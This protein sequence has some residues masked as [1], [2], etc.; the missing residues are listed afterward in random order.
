MIIDFGRHSV[1]GAI[2]VA[3]CLGLGPLSA[4][5]RVAP[6]LVSAFPPNG[7][8]SVPTD[9]VLRFTFSEAMKAQQAIQWVA[10]PTNFDSALIKYSWSADGRELSATMPTGWPAKLRI[11]WVF[12]RSQPAIPGRF[13]GVQGVEDLAGNPLLF[14]TGSFITAPAE[15]PPPVVTTNNCGVTSSHPLRAEISLAVISRFIQA[16]GTAAKPSSNLPIELQAVV[17]PGVGWASAVNLIDPAEKR[18]PLPKAGSGFALTEQYA[19]L[20]ALRAKRPAG[21]YRYECSDALGDLPS[22]LSLPLPDALPTIQLRNL[23]D[24]QAARASEPLSISWEA[25]GAAPGDYLSVQLSP[26]VGSEAKWASPDLGCPGALNGTSTSITVPGGTLS[27]GTNY[28]LELRLSRRQEATVL[29]HHA[30]SISTSE[31]AASILTCGTTPGRVR[32]LGVVCSTPPVEPSMRFDNPVLLAGKQLRLKLSP[33]VPH[34]AYQLYEWVQTQKRGVPLLSRVALADQ[35]IVATGNS[36]EFVLP[37]SSAPGAHL[38][39]AT[40]STGRR[41]ELPSR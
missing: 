14:G 36:V 6:T 27:E 33:T 16:A 5:D 12:Q 7:A 40:V 19:S 21:T 37:I 15:P 39:D 35:L 10:V 26:M 9:T 2:V 25:A 17:M 30:L 18:S 32:G 34:E 3:S 28:R 22:G 23:A 38:F 11:S 4:Q 31:T 20:D 1:L 41:G 13:P 24:L 29:S 8:A